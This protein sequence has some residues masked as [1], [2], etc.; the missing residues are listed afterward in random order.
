M[1]AMKVP[2]GTARKERRARCHHY[3][4]AMDGTEA[5]VVAYHDRSSED[6]RRVFAGSVK[7]A[8]KKAGIKPAKGTGDV[9]D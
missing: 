2:R 5:I 3:D 7:A 4:V 8:F 6:H 9:H 1:K